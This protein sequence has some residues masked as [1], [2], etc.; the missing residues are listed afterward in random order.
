MSVKVSL[1]RIGPLLSCRVG[2]STLF[3]C[4]LQIFVNIALQ[5]AHTV[6]S[7]VCRVVAGTLALDLPPHFGE[8]S[9]Q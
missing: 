9:A 1:R 6:E 5:S 8:C 4:S 7:D 2:S 3:T